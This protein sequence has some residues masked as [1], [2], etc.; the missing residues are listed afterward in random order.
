MRTRDRAFTAYEIH[1]QND[2]PIV[3]APLARD[4]M[5]ATDQRYAYRCLPLVVA[6]QA[7]W[8]VLNPVRFTARWNG[9]RERR[10]L[11]IRRERRD[12][13]VLI[14]FGSGVITFYMPYLF[15]T[16]RGINLWVKGPSNWIKDGAQ[17]LEGIV[18]SD[19]SAATFTMNWK[20]TRPNHTVTFDRDEPIC[21]LVPVPRGLAESLEPRRSPLA[22]NGKVDRTYRAWEQSRSQFIGG[23]NRR[24]PDV[25]RRGW[26]RHY[27]L[28]VSPDGDRFREHQTRLRLK[29]FARAGSATP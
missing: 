28:G 10:D 19:W 4:W 17:P 3:P 8:L 1:P 29:A 2:M 12:P 25:V 16:P 7:G 24:I 14:H 22:L 13:R 23:L 11:R 9:G 5:D 21:M 26:Q 18:E 27:F 20:L 6:N 15:R